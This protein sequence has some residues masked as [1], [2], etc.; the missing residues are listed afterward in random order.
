MYRRKYFVQKTRL[1]L[2]IAGIPLTRSLHESR[3]GSQGSILCLS[4][5]GRCLNIGVPKRWFTWSIFW[6]TWNKSQFDWLVTPI[7]KQRLISCVFVQTKCFIFCFCRRS[8]SLR[9]MLPW[10][11]SQSIILAPFAAP[12]FNSSIQTRRRYATDLVH[13]ELSLYQ[14]I[15]RVSEHKKMGQ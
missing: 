15:V 12:S 5:I 1:G 9:R 13:L 7:L 6:C 2:I 3:E 14:Y 11:V 8:M 4:L 10:I